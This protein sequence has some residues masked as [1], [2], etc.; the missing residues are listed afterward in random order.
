[1]ANSYSEVEET[2]SKMA[3]PT[4]WEAEDAEVA[5]MTPE[6]HASEYGTAF[7]DGSFSVE[8][9][10]QDRW[11]PIANGQVRHLLPLYGKLTLSRS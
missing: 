9:K 8:V 1:M 3:L 4:K 2:N 7:M 6:D 5:A 11:L 10:E